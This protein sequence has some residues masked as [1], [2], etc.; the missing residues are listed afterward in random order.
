MKR[1]IFWQKELVWIIFL[2]VIL[3]LCTYIPI[4]RNFQ[5]A[6]SERFYF[7]AEEFPI[8]QI[9]NLA[10]VRQGYLGDMF[11]TFNYSIFLGNHPSLVKF[12]YILIGHA[13]RIFHMDPIIMF[14]TVQFVLSIIFMLVVYILIRACFSRSSIRILAYVFVLFGTSISWPLQHFSFTDGAVYDVLVF[15]RMTV[16]MPHYLLGGIC[17]TLSLLFLSRALSHPKAY[18]SFIAASVTGVFASS[19]YAP[20]MVLIVSGFPLYILFD[21][22]STYGK[23]RIFKWNTS[24]IGTLIAYALVIA[25]PI[26]YVRYIVGYYWQDLNTAKL[27]FLNPFKL[28]FFEYVCALGIMFVISIFSIPTVIKRKNISLMLLA[29]WVI[30]HP[31]GEFFLSPYL[32]LNPIRYFLTPY[33]VGFGILAAVVIEEFGTLVIR[34]GQYRKQYTLYCVLVLLVLATGT[35][36]Y[37]RAFKRA[38]RCFCQY[39]I[40]DFAYPQRS[41]M[42]GISWLRTHTNPSDIVL[43]GYRAGMLIPAFS[44]N[45]VYTSWWYKLIQPSSFPIV[46]DGLADFYRQNLSED[47]AKAYLKRYNISYIFYSDEEYMLKPSA[48]GLQYPFL[49]E[50][51]NHAGVMI[52]TVK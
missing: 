43:S 24:A 22:I 5:R 16:A 48:W 41:V 15:Q 8:D 52:Y 27:E 36:T 32:H 31:I 2:S 19:F 6:P 50:V 9:G 14:R 29:T 17:S 51:Y 21:A 46:L 13:A 33:F 18:G 20:N 44:G 35:Y 11:A 7:G 34:I 38:N 12:E 39:G 42:D 25:I 40:L 28:T 4:Y 3:L 45:R 23:T 1:V 10:Y 37:A 47:D 26:V 30:V 49:T